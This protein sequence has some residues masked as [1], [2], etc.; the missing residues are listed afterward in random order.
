MDFS[1]LGPLVG[2]AAAVGLGFAWW[3][4]RRAFRRL[5]EVRCWLCER[6]VEP[7]GR[8]D[9]YGCA[10]CGFDTRAAQD[11]SIATPVAS[12]SNILAALLELRAA[13]QAYGEAY[14]L[15][16]ALLT[17]ASG[18]GPSSVPSD[19]KARLHDHEATARLFLERVDPELAQLPGDI[20]RRIETLEGIVDD[21]RAQVR[22]HFQAAP[23]RS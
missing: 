18:Y 20:D 1:Y 9:D 2:G 3:R 10:A 17:A 16:G 14:G 7:R 11:P 4:R 15:G 6:P 19:A 8:S 21:L 13:R 12:L 22:S 5:L 23:Y